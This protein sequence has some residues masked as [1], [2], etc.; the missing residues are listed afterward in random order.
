MQEKFQ[1]K[2]KKIFNLKQKYN[3]ITIGIKTFKC[4][5]N[6]LITK[7]ILIK[8]KLNSKIN[9][10]TINIYKTNNIF[11]LYGNR[12]LGF[13]INIILRNFILINLISSVFGQENF[14][15]NNNNYT[16]NIIKLKVKKSIILDEDYYD[17]IPIIGTEIYPTL[18]LYNDNEIEIDEDGCINIED[19][20]E[21]YDIILVYYYTIDTF[22]NLF[23][24]CRDI[25]EIDLSNVNTSSV[26]SMRGMFCNCENLKYI[27]FGNIDTSCVTDMSYLF[28]Y[29]LLLSSIDLS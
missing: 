23:F 16:E 22:E 13:I 19:P 27:N 29:C 7:I 9:Q 21:I 2:N 8:Q 14:N 10:E 11:E 17:C 4:I 6:K 20:E 15:T 25:I 12:K 26:T 1:N 24:N 3:K 5:N 18:A 28:N